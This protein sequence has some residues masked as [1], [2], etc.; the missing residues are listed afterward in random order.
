MEDRSPNHWPEWQ[1][2][3]QQ[4]PFVVPEAVVSDLCATTPAEAL[5]TLLGALVDAGVIPETQQGAAFAGL[6][7]R[8]ALASTGIGYGVA[9]PHTKHDSVNKVSAAVGYSRS[10]ID[11]LSVDGQ[12]VHLI[13]LIVSPPHNSTEYLQALQTIAGVVRCQ[14]EH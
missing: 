1:A 11:F 13:V 14:Q 7:R 10:G 3:I 5:R 12:P 8:E 2:M 6:L 9:I 4:L